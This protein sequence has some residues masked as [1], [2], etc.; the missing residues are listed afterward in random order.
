MGGMGQVYEVFDSEL[1]RICVLKSLHSYLN[2]GGA[3]AEQLTKEAQ[4]LAQLSHPNIVNVFNIGI[5]EDK[6]SLPYYV[7]EKLQGQSLQKL[8]NQYTKE[9]KTLPLPYCY[10]IAIALLEALSKAH[11][12]SPSF[13]H[14]D[15]KPSNIFIHDPGNGRGITKLVDFGLA[16][17]W[18]PSQSNSQS[19]FIG[20]YA[21]ASPEQKEGKPL[22]PL[23][24]LYSA[25][26]VLYEIITGHLPSLPCSD[27]MDSRP[28]IP[29]ELDNLI[30]SALHPDLEQRPKSAQAFAEALRTLQKQ[31]RYIALD[32]K[33]FIPSEPHRETG[34]ENNTLPNL[35]SLLH[36]S[37]REQ[38]FAPFPLQFKRERKRFLIFPSVSHFWMGIAFF[39]MGIS[40]IT[41]ALFLIQP[42]GPSRPEPVGT[43]EQKENTP[44]TSASSP[45]LTT[46]TSK[47]VERKGVDEPS[48][49]PR[50]TLQISP[51]PNKAH[52][53]SPSKERVK[54]SHS[55]KKRHKIESPDLD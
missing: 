2:V 52:A 40:I 51:P 16:I 43:S 54:P 46:D 47:P 13:L 25:G 14:R 36:S 41:L 35:L 39:M 17:P 26:L 38:S 37:S 12:H 20:T 1:Q 32:S 9:G 31:K 50:S 48:N 19:G 8:L 45:T 10:E 53:R 29:Q 3:F 15:V 34:G 42:R 44:P 55:R 7:M 23:S 11:T 30:H 28:S 22:T 6:L 27:L 49:L 4:I 18:Q 24:D 33:I 5:T 21:Y